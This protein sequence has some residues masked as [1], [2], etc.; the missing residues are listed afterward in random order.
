MYYSELKTKR[1]NWNW[2][3]IFSTEENSESKRYEDYWNGIYMYLEK[4]LDNDFSAIRFQSEHDDRFVLLTKDF[5][6]ELK[7]R[8]TYFD[9]LGP[10]M[11]ENYS[12]DSREKEN[13]YRVIAN[14]SGEQIRTEVYSSEEEFEDEYFQDVS[15]CVTDY[16]GAEEIEIER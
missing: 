13:L 16:F 11:H 15:S 2:Q 9:E 12:L 1:E 4:L 5:E 7:Y 10:V 14:Y 3:L 8:L 6:S